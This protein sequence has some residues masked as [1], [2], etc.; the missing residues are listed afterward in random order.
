MIVAGDAAKA[1]AENRPAR[2]VDLFGSD[3]DRVERNGD[4]ASGDIEDRLERGSGRSLLQGDE[5]TVER[6][7]KADPRTSIRSV[8]DGEAKAN[9]PAFRTAPV[10]GA[11][12]DEGFQAAQHRARLRPAGVPVRGTA[13]IAIM[14][15]LVT[16]GSG[17]I[18]LHTVRALLDLGEDVVAT[19]FR[20]RREPEFIRSELGGRLARE[21]VD[22][23][24]P[25]ALHDV[26]RKHPITGVVHL[27]VTPQGAISPAEE[28]RVMITGW[29]NVL[30]MAEAY[31]VKRVTLASSIALYGGIEKDRYFEDMPLPMTTDPRMSTGAI[32]KAEESLGLQYGDRAGF[33][34]VAGRMPGVWGPMYHS[35]V[36]PPSRMVHR[37]VRKDTSIVVDNIGA[38]QQ[39][40]YLYVKDAGRGLAMLQT[41]PKL[42]QRIYHIGS[43]RAT[44]HAEM[45]EAIRAIIPDADLPIDPNPR[46][47]MPVSGILDHTAL[48]RDTGYAPKYDA[49]T[50]IAEY[51]DWVRSHDF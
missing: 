21:T 11:T 39:R 47:N 45:L 15:V 31:K 38:T 23:T 8:H 34:V 27:S 9:P 29:T 20:V 42:A 14:A 37:A 48:T 25:Y 16:G 51:V 28:I 32:K 33:E 41:A 19:Q 5:T 13:V 18:G 3:A 10:G 12:G 50:G 2:A 43:G 26:F 1:A 7:V 17:F 22:I 46:P 40:D 30:A 4:G 35:M 44:T 24:S 36:N 49:K 6:E